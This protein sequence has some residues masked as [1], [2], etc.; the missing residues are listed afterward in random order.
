[1]ALWAF[2]IILTTGTNQHLK[3]ERGTT[4]KLIQGRR[5]TQSGAA[6]FSIQGSKI[7]QMQLYFNNLLEPVDDKPRETGTYVFPPPSHT[8]RTVLDNI[9]SGLRLR[10]EKLA[11]D[12]GMVQIFLSQA[13]G[14]CHS[15]FGW[16]NKEYHDLEEYLAPSQLLVCCSTL[17]SK[18]LLSINRAV[19]MQSAIRHFAHLPACFT[20]LH[21]QPMTVEYKNRDFRLVTWHQLNHCDVH[22]KIRS[23]QEWKGRS[24]DRWWQ[25]FQERVHN[26]PPEICNMIMDVVYTSFGPRRVYPGIERPLTNIFL[27][28][29]KASVEIYH[30][31]YWSGNTWVVDEGP[32][33]DAMRFMTQAPFNT[34]TTDFSRQTPNAAALQIRSIE[35]S[36]SQKD[37]CSRTRLSRV[38][39][40]QTPD[41]ALPG[42]KSPQLR[43]SS[44]CPSIPEQSVSNIKKYEFDLYQIWQ[45]KF[46]RIAFLN[47]Q[48]LVLDLREAYAPAGEYIGVNAVQRLIPFYYGMPTDFQI[49]APSE[50]LR[51][52]IRKI[53]DALNASTPTGSRDGV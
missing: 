15:S 8:S 37:L 10:S 7:H 2:C 51:D 31:L 18:S 41:T 3:I 26:L 12:A 5:K 45:D 21:K 28:L 11:V 25:R 32:V 38:D 46:D 6:E 42:Q 33:N 48:H 27:S 49:L 50:S 47:L 24:S 23:D 19:A 39:K 17:Y 29:D 35:L 22:N 4:V 20:N 9:R 14:H 40:P 16:T 1:M 44:Q 34:S 53:F 52:E 13:A 30:E 43:Q 36:F